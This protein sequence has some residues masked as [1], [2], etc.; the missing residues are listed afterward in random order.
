MLGT[1]VNG[2]INRHAI[3]SSY[4]KPLP[5]EGGS[6]LERHL[7]YRARIGGKGWVVLLSPVRAR[8][9]TAASPSSALLPKEYLSDMLPKKV[10]S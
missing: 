8:S 4:R 6:H 10:T 9:P 7:Q 3:F 5:V 1:A 2:T